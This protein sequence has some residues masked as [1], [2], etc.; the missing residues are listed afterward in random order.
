MAELL[1]EGRTAIFLLYLAYS[2]PIEISSWL[3][4]VLI[5]GARVS[6]EISDNFGVGK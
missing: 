2:K 1:C 5:N 4:R 3:A 6:Q